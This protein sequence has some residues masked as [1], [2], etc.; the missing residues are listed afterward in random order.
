MNI[1]QA[2]KMNIL[3]LIS[4]A[5]ADK[6]TIGY[7]LGSLLLFKVADLEVDVLAAIPAALVLGAAIWKHYQGGRKQQAEAQKAINEN[8]IL[9]KKLK[10][11]EKDF[12]EATIENQILLQKLEQEILTT[13][14]MKQQSDSAKN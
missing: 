14:R 6:V 5:I 3:D 10:I 4:Q 7:T 1:S 13:E 9:K 8:N 12:E 2:R 11:A